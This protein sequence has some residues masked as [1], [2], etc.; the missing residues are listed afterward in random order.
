M[1][2]KIFL[3]Q[4]VLTFLIGSCWIYFT[5]LAGLRFGSKTGG[6][7]GGLPST[8]LLSFFFIGFTQSPEIASTATTVFPLA[9]AI[10][11]LFLIVYVSIVPAGFLKAI[12]TSLG[13]WFFSSGI[14]LFLKCDNFLLNLAIYVVVILFA[15]LVLEK[16]FLIKSVVSDNTGN[17][18][19]H[20][21]VRSAFG[22]FVVTLTVLF[23]KTG[24]HLIG[25]IMAAFPAMFISML[26][27]SYKAQGI[28]FSRAMTK[29]LLVT[30]MITV[31]VYAIALRYMYVYTGLYFGT[32]FSLC[33]SGVSAYLTYRFILP[34][35]I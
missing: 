4:L 1:I 28:E 24:G 15:Y 20:L 35:L 12:L 19:K 33:F 8:A 25:G 21:V 5:V 9:M 23:A 16:Y 18:E 34:G 10:S 14:V 26:T 6:F 22:G 27:I 17:P 3:L 13:F 11:I 29:P 30:G 7:I 31:A 32:F 2:T